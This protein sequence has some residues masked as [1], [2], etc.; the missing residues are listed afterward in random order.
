[1]CDPGEIGVCYEVYQLNGRHGYSF[2]FESGR[3]DGF[4]PGDVRMFLDLTG[5]VCEVIADY[6]FQ[7]VMKL[8]RDY[9]NGRFAAAFPPQTRRV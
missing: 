4:S 3:S 1:M 6:Q 2:I 5:R 9:R 7:N 8:T